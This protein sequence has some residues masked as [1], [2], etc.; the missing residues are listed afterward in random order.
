MN[1]KMLNKKCD[2]FA[3]QS[4]HS[5]YQTGQFLDQSW[6]RDLPE[7]KHDIMNDKRKCVNTVREVLGPKRGCWDE[8][9]NSWKDRMKSGKAVPVFKRGTLDMW[10]GSSA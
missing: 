6:K 9:V 7:R 2:V 5:I 8:F 1:W 3:I 4:Q 10:Y